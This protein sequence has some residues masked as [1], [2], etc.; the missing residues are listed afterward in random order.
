[1]VK[2]RMYP[3]YQGEYCARNNPRGHERPAPALRV[4]VRGLKL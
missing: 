4:P 3:V 1:M 2:H